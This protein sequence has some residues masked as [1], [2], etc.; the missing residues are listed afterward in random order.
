LLGDN[1]TAAW[2]GHLHVGQEAFKKPETAF[3]LQ[4]TLDGDEWVINGQK[5]AWV[6]D[7]TIATHALAFLGVDKSRGASGG[8]V[9]IIP[10]TARRDK[11]KPLDKLGSVL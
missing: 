6:S 2:S 10:L 9:A 11:G 8:A 3:E 1:G 7:G 4:A 5:S